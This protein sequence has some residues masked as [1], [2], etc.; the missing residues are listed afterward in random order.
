MN[1]SVKLKAEQIARLRVQGV[2]GTRIAIELGMS[3]DGLMR[4]VKTE[5]YQQIEQEVQG[6]LLGQMDATLSKRADM[7]KKMADEMEDDAVPEA[8]KVV[9]ETMRKRRDLKTAL[10]ILDRDP[11]RQFAKGASNAAAQA[12]AGPPARQPLDSK[13]LTQ[14]MSDADI[15]HD[16]LEKTKTTKVAQA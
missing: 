8:W 14:A 15:T 12:A 5:E 16:L 3:Y 1:R 6:V 7:R 9:L 13:V 10:E 11:K 4:I 2:P